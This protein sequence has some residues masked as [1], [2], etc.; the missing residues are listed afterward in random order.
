MIFYY[1]LFIGEV[2]T[3]RNETTYP[4]HGKYPLNRLGG[5]TP[6]DG[7]S[8]AVWRLFYC[9]VTVVTQSWD[10]RHRS[11]ASRQ[12]KLDGYPSLQPHTFDGKPVHDF[13][14]PFTHWRSQ[15][16]TKRN[17]ISNPRKISIEPKFCDSWDSIIQFFFQ[18]VVDVLA[19]RLDIPAK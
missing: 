13:L 1:H 7:C 16:Y 3:I 17:N 10:G 9:C 19:N 5:W 11:W 12:S 18:S 2:G 14:L 6:S 15:D 4:I 8:I